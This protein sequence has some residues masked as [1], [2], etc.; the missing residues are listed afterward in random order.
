M[1][2]S[3]QPKPKKR[4]RLFVWLAILV[5]LFAAYSAGWYA[6]ANKVRG[7]VGAAIAAINAGGANADCANM[8]VSGYPLRLVVSCDNLAYEND[9]T[10]VAASTGRMDAMARIYRPLS[11]VAD[12]VGPL[13]TSAPGMAPLWLDWDKMRAAA[14]LSLTS[15]AGLAL[16]GEG[17]SGQTDP[18]DDSEPVQLFSAGK[19]E[20]MLQ[21]VGQDVDA[22]FSFSD[23]QVDAEALD[24]RVLPP[25]NG[26]GAATLKNGLA[27]LGAKAE[28]LRGQSIDIGQLELS[29]GTAHISVSGPIEVD[30]DGLID[31]SLTIRLQDPKAAAAILGAAIPEQKR[32]IEQG[33]S[34]LAMFGSEPTMPLKITK[35]KA[36]LGFIPLGDIKPVQ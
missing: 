22:G 10:N 24:G 29:S 5:A 19:A 14:S 34:A 12:I 33:F 36:S 6:L 25:L 16:R 18:Q 8:S 35:G 13:R 3:D 28:T 2:A 21:P 9:T 26:A 4:S 11:P 15:T 31:A 27:L 7:E 32:Q 23:L 17:V 30:A 20:V 1:T